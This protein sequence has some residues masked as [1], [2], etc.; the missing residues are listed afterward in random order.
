MKYKI[1][2]HRNATVLFTHD[3]KY[4]HLYQEIIE[5]LE[6]IDDETIKK[7]YEENSRENIKS[8]SA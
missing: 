4:K 1:H 8:L 3:E 7:A 2:S 6:N 5:V